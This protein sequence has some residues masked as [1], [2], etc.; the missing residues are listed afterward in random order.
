[1][2]IEKYRITDKNIVPAKKDGYKGSAI[3]HQQQYKQK[4]N[5][6]STSF[7][8]IKRCMEKRMKKG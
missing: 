5:N 2:N 1:M 6:P 3:S 7:T 8:E 4:L